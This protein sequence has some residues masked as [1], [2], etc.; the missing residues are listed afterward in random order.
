VSRTQSRDDFGAALTLKNNAETSLQ[1]G[2]LVEG[3]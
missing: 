3:C 2:F 1:V